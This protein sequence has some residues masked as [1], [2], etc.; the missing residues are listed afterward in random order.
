MWRHV[1]F[2]LEDLCDN[3]V[4]HVSTSNDETNVWHSRLLHVNFGC[5]LWLANMILV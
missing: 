5:M 3:V 4:S 2:L 1:S